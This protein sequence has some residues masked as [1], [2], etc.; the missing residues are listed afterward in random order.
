MKAC[1]SPT[2][3]HN[4]FHR[5]FHLEGG[6]PTWTS[7]GLSAVTMCAAKLRAGVPSSTFQECASGLTHYPQLPDVE[8]RSMQLLET[9]AAPAIQPCSAGK[10]DCLPVCRYTQL[11]SPC[12]TTD[13]TPIIQVAHQPLF[14]RCLLSTPTPSPLHAAPCMNSSC[15]LLARA[16]PLSSGWQVRVNVACLTRE[17]C[18]HVTVHACMGA[19]SEKDGGA[20]WGWHCGG[21][22]SLQ[23]THGLA[24]RCVGALDLPGRRQGGEHRRVCMHA[25]TAFTRH[26]GLVGVAGGQH[27]E[28]HRSRQCATSQ[29]Q[30]L[31]E[32]AQ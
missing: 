19:L 11:L 10:R 17:T 32:Q 9:H 3:T 2:C 7:I 8:S 24:L 28:R 20:S 13:T 1:R 31:V 22:L 5:Y 16:P 15:Q 23:S 26:D 12:D 25:G 27:A 4:C 30:L 18:R 6:L 21:V 14:L 29:S